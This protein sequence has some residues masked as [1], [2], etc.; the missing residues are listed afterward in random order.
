MPLAPKAMKIGKYQISRRLSSV[1]MCV[2]ASFVWR[3]REW[4]P[5]RSTILTL[6]LT[7]FISLPG[8]HTHRRKY[9][10]YWT[11]THTQCNLQRGPATFCGI[12]WRR[13]FY[14]KAI[15]YYVDAFYAFPAL[16]SPVVVVVRVLWPRRFIIKRPR[17]L[18]LDQTD[19][20]VINY[21][22]TSR[23]AFIFICG[24]RLRLLDGQTIYNQKPQKKMICFYNHELYR[25]LDT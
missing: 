22:N 4:T 12:N 10:H 19:G 5:L 24:R 16:V 3:G 7:H 9:T 17:H 13:G 11:H 15:S 25:R 21:V 23:K 18:H 8:T 1:C 14:H 2:C 6:F 20:S